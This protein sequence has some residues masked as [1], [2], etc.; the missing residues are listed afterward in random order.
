MKAEEP[1][2]AQEE[3]APS[4]NTVASTEAAVEGE[5]DFNSFRE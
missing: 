3:Q 5:Y 2:A 4:N 1:A